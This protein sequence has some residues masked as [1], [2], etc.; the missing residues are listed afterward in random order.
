MNPVLAEVVK[1][2]RLERIEENIF[3][4]ESRDIG[5]PQGTVAVFPI[6]GW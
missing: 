6:V 4:G 1:L 5:R 3:H 2:L